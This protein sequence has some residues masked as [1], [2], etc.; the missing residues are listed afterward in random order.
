MKGMEIKNARLG[1]A[2]VGALTLAS[3]HAQAATVT[4]SGS[5]GLLAAQATFA[6][7]GATLI[8]TLKNTSAADVLVPT[9]VLGAVFFNVAGNPTLTRTSAVVPAGSSVFLRTT[10]LAVTVVGGEWSY[11][12]SLAQYSANSGIGS[13]GFGIFG[14]GNVFPGGNLSGPASP[15]GLQYGIT[16]QG[17]NGATGNVA[18]T[19]TE[20]IKNQVV[21]TLGGLPAGFDPATGITNVTFQYGTVITDANFT[22]VV[23]L[24]AAG[25]MLVAGLGILYRVG[26]LGASSAANRLERTAAAI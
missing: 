13:G 15:D 16:S 3:V 5:S 4:F 24:P 18:V 23:P 22:G 26:R 10:P 25:W 14:P 21:F 7:S 20:L 8:V 11:L 2:L 1:R 9:D 19:S 17:D 12:N 6:T